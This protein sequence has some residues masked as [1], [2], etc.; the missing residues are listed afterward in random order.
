MRLGVSLG[1]TASTGCVAK[2]QEADVCKSYLGAI[3]SI[4]TTGS[5]A[6]LGAIHSIL[7]TGSLAAILHSVKMMPLNF[8]GEELAHGAGESA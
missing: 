7:T 2:Q 6:Y 5:L 4:L 8:S 1:G 3:H